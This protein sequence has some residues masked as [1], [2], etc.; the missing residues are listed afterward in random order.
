MSTVLL[1]QLHT[2]NEVDHA[3]KRTEDKVLV[4]R[5]GRED[6]AECMKLDDLVSQ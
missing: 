4:L 3:I 5:F 6:E 1:Q 2:K